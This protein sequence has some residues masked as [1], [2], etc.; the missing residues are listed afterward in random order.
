M[1]GLVE[2]KCSMV[3]SKLSKDF[4]FSCLHPQNW[5]KGKGFLCVSSPILSSFYLLSHLI[6]LSAVNS[7][8]FY[9]IAPVLLEVH[10]LRTPAESLF[11]LMKTQKR[12]CISLSVNNFSSSTTV[13]P[14]KRNPDADFLPCFSPEEEKLRR[15]EDSDTTLQ[16]S[17]DK[18]EMKI[19]PSSLTTYFECN[20]ICRPCHKKNID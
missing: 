18:T 19:T 12:A 14:L 15:L 9:P 4:R 13:L 6:P 10:A 16:S 7:M 2:V 3:S 1:Q 17:N 5:Q 8:C 20:S 11:K